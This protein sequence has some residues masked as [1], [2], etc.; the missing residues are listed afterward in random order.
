MKKLLR[1]PGGSDLQALLKDKGKEKNPPHSSKQE[2]TVKLCPTL[3]TPRKHG[4]EGSA[5]PEGNINPKRQVPSYLS[6]CLPGHFCVLF[7]GHKLS[8]KQSNLFL[9]LL[10][11][12]CQ[13]VQEK[14]LQSQSQ[15]VQGE[16]RN[17]GL[18]QLYPTIIMSAKNGI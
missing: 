18:N 17:L 3:C 11:S 10:D 8:F 4:P 5:L 7:L 13:L 15:T 1:R 12:P 14:V 6:D 2:Q 16:P 9:E